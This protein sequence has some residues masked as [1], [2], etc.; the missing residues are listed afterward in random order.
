MASGLKCVIDDAVGIHRGGGAAGTKPGGSPQ[1]GI[2]GLIR[3]VLVVAP[4]RHKPDMAVRKQHVHPVGIIAR[5]VQNI[6]DGVN[7]SEQMAL[8]GSTCEVLSGVS[9][10]ILL[11]ASFGL[12]LVKVCDE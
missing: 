7:V 4:D 10:V 11:G 8:V 12:G 9:V 6:R 1:I 2:E 5:F 3:F